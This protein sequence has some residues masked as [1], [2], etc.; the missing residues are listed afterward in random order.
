MRLAIAL[1]LTLG[2]STVHADVRWD[3][4]AGAGMEGGLISGALRPDGVAQAGTAAEVLLPVRDW[5]F[6]VNLEAVARLTS[7]FDAAAETTLDLMWRYARP[8]RAFGFGVGAG[9]RQLTFAPDKG[10]TAESVYGVDLVRLDLHGRIASWSTGTTSLGL[11]LY[12]AWTFGCYSGTRNAAP[13]GD[14]LPPPRDV[15]CVGTITST[16]VGGVETSVVWK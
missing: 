11:D 16:Y 5:G 12:F 6:G 10:G 7:R 13:S 1:L 2:T 3:V 8:D 14:M 15:S 4:H 9:V